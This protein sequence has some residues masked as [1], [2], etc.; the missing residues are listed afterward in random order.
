MKNY[1]VAFV[2]EYDSEGYTKATY[3]QVQRRVRFI[4]W[5]WL[6]V[7]FYD[8]KECALMHATRME[9]CE[10]RKKEITIISK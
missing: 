6:H 2:R 1:R 3:Y 9:L 10:G 5:L 8:K 4:P 7:K